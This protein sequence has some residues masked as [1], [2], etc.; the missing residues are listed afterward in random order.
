V[1]P[2]SLSICTRAYTPGAWGAPAA[3]GA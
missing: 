2:C 3:E 1:L